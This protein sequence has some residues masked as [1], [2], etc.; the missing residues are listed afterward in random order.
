MNL[1]STPRWH[2]AQLILIMVEGLPVATRHAKRF[3]AFAARPHGQTSTFV[4]SPPVKLYVRL[5]KAPLQTP[6]SVLAQSVTSPSLNRLVATSLF[7]CAA[8]P[9][10]MYAERRSARR[11]T[12]TSVSTFARTLAAS[13]PS[14]NDAIFI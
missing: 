12:C 5:S 4:T 8:T 3:L 6:S 9:C 2:N 14:A 7:A 13:A 11:D 1:C 10:V